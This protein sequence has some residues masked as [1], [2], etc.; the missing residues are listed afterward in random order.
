M[1]YK[2]AEKYNYEIIRFNTYKGNNIVNFKDNF[3][4][5]IIYQPELSTHI[6]NENDKFKIIKFFQ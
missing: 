6:F 4:K 1:C 5:K 3:I 2:Y